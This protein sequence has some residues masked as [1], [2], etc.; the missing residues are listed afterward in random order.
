MKWRKLLVMVSIGLALTMITV[1]ICDIRNPMMGFMLRNPARTYVVALC[2]CTIAEGAI[3]G[4]EPKKKKK[5][6]PAPVP[7]EGDEP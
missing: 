4:Y 2:L 1:V 3:I 6:R 7:T 5:K